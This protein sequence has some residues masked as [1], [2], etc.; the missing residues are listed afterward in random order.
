MWA[1]SADRIP[2]ANHYQLIDKENTKPSSLLLIESWYKALIGKFINETVWSGLHE[3]CQ[4]D[5]IYSLCHNGRHGNVIYVCRSRASQPVQ[6][7]HG[8]VHRKTQ[9]GHAMIDRYVHV[10][11]LTEYYHMRVYRRIYALLSLN[12]LI[13]LAWYKFIL[14]PNQ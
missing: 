12:E 14:W 2:S 8:V 13:S 9:F 5:D 10:F 11:N 3:K 7:T 4:T 6:Y 1:W